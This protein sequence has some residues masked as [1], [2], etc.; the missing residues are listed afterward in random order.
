MAHRMA[1][2]LA[3]CAWPMACDGWEPPLPAE[4]PT[5]TGGQALTQ[6]E[7]DCAGMCSH[8]IANGCEPGDCAVRCVHSVNN[9][10][11]CVDVTHQ[12]VACLSNAGLES[13]TM[14]PPSCQAS[15]DAWTMCAGVDGGCGPVQCVDPGGLHCK[16]Q[17]TCDSQKVVEACIETELGFHCTCEVGGVVVNECLDP[18]LSCGFFIGCC[19]PELARSG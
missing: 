8:A 13:C 6:I 5:T 4:D 10:G 16:C 18:L 14:V 19:A 1:M 12:Y 7:R 17:A 2:F 3:L 15:Y 11:A 9:A